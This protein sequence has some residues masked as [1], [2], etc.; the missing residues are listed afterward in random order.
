VPSEQ[1]ARGHD[2][3]GQDWQIEFVD[4]LWP[5]EKFENSFCRL[6]LLHFLHLYLR[7]VLVFSKNSIIYPQSLH[8][9]SN[10]G[11]IP[12]RYYPEGVFVIIR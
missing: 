11:T 1:V 8:L 5:I 9:Y 3:S 12:P 6:E 2:K 7:A 4:L 10:I